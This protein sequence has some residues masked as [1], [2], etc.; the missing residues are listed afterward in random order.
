VKDTL[1]QNA[2][3][4]S[5]KFDVPPSVT[6]R[7]VILAVPMDGRHGTGVVAVVVGGG[8]VGEGVGLSVGRGDGVAAGEGV[9]V[10]LAP[11]ATC[12]S[13]VATGVGF[14]IVGEAVAV[15]PLPVVGVR[16]AAMMAAFVF[17]AL[18]SVVAFA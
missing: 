7:S 4:K 3:L 5:G 1:A 15:A 14:R 2:W 6:V 16:V 10:A 17:V 18:G 8:D 12:A 9:L 13:E 11:A